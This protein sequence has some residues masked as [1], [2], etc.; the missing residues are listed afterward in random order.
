MS[1]PYPSCGRH[2]LY[3]EMKYGGNKPTAEQRRWLDELSSLG[4]ATAV[5]YSAEEAIK[6]IM[7]YLEGKYESDTSSAQ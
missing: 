5:C 3:I 6:V 7:N 2:G 4:Y 1:L